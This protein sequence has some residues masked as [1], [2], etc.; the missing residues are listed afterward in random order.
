MGSIS[1]VM[2]YS[3]S[4]H[5]HRAHLII[6]LVEAIQ[7]IPGSAFQVHFNIEMR[8]RIFLI[9]ASAFLC[10]TIDSPLTLLASL[11]VGF[12]GILSLY[13]ALWGASR[14][15]S[16]VRIVWQDG[17]HLA[18]E[19]RVEL[20]PELFQ[21]FLWRLLRPP[22]QSTVGAGASREGRSVNH[23]R[24][25]VLAIQSRHRRVFFAR[26]KE[27]QSLAS[28]DDQSMKRKRSLLTKTKDCSTAPSIYKLVLFVR[29]PL[30]RYG[31]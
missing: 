19:P 11:F 10:N 5:P 13:D 27:P 24:E 17:V 31:G 23:V 16:S 7:A 22:A 3:N 18:R 20:L 6:L 26:E 14:L 9:E 8:V 1:N 2:A 12:P 21:V 30:V 29:A 28:K 25:V 15:G 4:F